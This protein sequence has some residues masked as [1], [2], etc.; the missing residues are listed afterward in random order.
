MRSD[1]VP[2]CF[3]RYIIVIVKARQNT[4]SWFEESKCGCQ[5]FYLKSLK[6]IGQVPS[7]VDIFAEGTSSKQPIF[8]EVYHVCESQKAH[9]PSKSYLLNLIDITLEL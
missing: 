9:H 2:G 7:Q 4:N 8:T 6:L 3:A 5:D 1:Q